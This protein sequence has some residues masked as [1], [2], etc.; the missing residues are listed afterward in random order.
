MKNKPG[1]RDSASQKEPTYRKVSFAHAPQNPGTA[2]IA[3]IAARVA[4]A[5]PW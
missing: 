5:E 1:R 2:V 3:V 4:A